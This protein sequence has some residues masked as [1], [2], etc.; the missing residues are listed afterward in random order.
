LDE[1]RLPPLV[2][3]VAPRPALDIGDALRVVDVA[4]NLS[5]GHGQRVRPAV[6][7]VRLAKDLDHGGR[8]AG[9]VVE[10]VGLARCRRLGEVLAADVPEEL[11]DRLRELLVRALEEDELLALFVVGV[12]LGDV[13]DAALGRR[14][15]LVGIRAPHIEEFDVPVA[16]AVLAEGGVDVRGL[17]DLDVH[18]LQA[19]VL[20]MRNPD[21]VD[22][23]FHRQVL[24]EWSLE[25]FPEV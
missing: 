23:F 11:V 17:A 14:E 25:V 9:V 5:D 20:Q 24:C 2:H 15:G 18:D 1:I 4:K 22:H 3:E 16:A 12:L 13:V 19:R 7:V 10:V 6:H 21:R 8:R